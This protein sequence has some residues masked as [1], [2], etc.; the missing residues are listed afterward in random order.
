MFGMNIVQRL[1][2]NCLFA[3][4]DVCGIDG[5]EQNAK[6]G[7]DKRKDGDFVFFSCEV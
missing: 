4:V 7:G 3:A 2:R 1:N 6:H 5:D